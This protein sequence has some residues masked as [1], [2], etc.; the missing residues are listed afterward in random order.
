MPKRKANVASKSRWPLAV[1]QIFYKEVKVPFFGKVV[2]TPN[3]QEENNYYHVIYDDGDEE[4]MDLDEVTTHVRYYKELE[5]KKSNVS[6]EEKTNMLQD[7]QS[8]SPSLETMIGT[9]IAKDFVSEEN[10]CGHIQKIKT[11]KM[12]ESTYIVSY[13]LT[14]TEAELSKDELEPLVHATIE[15]AIVDIKEKDLTLF[16]Q[17][18][19]NIDEILPAI[20]KI[21]PRH[22]SRAKYLAEFLLFCTERQAIW[23]KRRRNES[24]PWTKDQVLATRHISNIYRELD[25][26]RI[27]F[28]RQMLNLQSEVEGMMKDDENPNKPQ[29]L[30]LEIGSRIL[31]SAVLFTA[32]TKVSTFEKAGGIPRPVQMEC[33]KFRKYL[34]KMDRN[35]EIIFGASY[36]TMGVE[37]LVRTMTSLSKN[38]QKKLRCITREIFALGSDLKAIS[39]VIMQIENIDAFYT[40]QIT[41]YLIES[42]M[43]PVNDKDCNWFKLGPGARAGLKIIFGENALNQ[44][45]GN[46]LCLFIQNHHQDI[47]QVLG[48]SIRGYDGKSLNSQK[49]VEHALCEYKKYLK[50][51]GRR[52]FWSTNRDSLGMNGC[53]TC[54]QRFEECKDRESDVCSRCKSLANGEWLV[55]K[56]E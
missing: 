16:Q 3:E 53:V 18:D 15:D 51:N 34:R 7:L 27:Y 50:W 46:D 55:S 38:S 29:E 42:G 24:F 21:L 5:I 19:I 17:Y 35:G 47:L 14:K 44:Y 22:K 45:D 56:G 25:A 33:E 9:R 37:R 36:Q 31:W 8:F 40:G 10:S 54:G 6:Q 32:V 20:K 30:Q 1:N 11:G 41:G 39:E 52:L 2:S 4:D 49:T 28:R 13:P 12:N 26:R 23:W 43:I 48:C